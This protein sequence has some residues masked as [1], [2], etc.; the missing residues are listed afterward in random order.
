M[1]AGIYDDQNKLIAGLSISSP[2]DRLDEGWLTKL[3]ATANEI[4]AG[5]GHKVPPQKAAA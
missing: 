3:Q 1:A 2:A 5:L 4:S